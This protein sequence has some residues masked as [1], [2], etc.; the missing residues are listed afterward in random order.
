MTH[1]KVTQRHMEENCH[2]GARQ[3]SKSAGIQG[4]AHKLLVFPCDWIHP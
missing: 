2:I 1:R 4:W 3:A